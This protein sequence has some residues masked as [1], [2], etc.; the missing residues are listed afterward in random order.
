MPNLLSFPTA[1]ISVG[2]ETAISPAKRP[3]VFHPNQR[4][5]VF[6]HIFVNVGFSQ[7]VQYF[8][9][10]VTTAQKAD[11]T[12]RRSER[13]VQHQISEA[14]AMGQGCCRCIIEVLL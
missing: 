7:L 2:I 6:D 3:Q 1:M 12:F 10:G 8:G 9:I 5:Q 13:C 4:M 14:R 11:M